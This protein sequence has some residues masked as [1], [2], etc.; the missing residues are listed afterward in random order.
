MEKLKVILVVLNK[1]FLRSAL[2]ILNYS[3]ATPVVILMDG[4]EK[5]I[6]LGEKVRIQVV[7]FASLNKVIVLGKNFLW[8]ICGKTSD[9]DAPAKLKKFLAAN[10]VPENNILNFEVMEQ[11]NPLWLANLRYVEENPIESFATGDDFTTC[12]LD[13]NKLPEITGVNLAAPNQ[14]LRQSFLIAQHVFKHSKRGTIKHVFIGLA[15]YS[16]R[17]DSRKK[18]STCADDIA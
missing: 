5:F 8:L 9:I 4:D 13:F 15:P 17:V 12:G 11:I 18:F 2:A 7:P 1:N 10:D 3:K 14:D 6:K 16:L